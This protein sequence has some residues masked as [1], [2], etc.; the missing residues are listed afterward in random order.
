MFCVGSEPGKMQRRGEL[1]SKWRK[2]RT[3][4]AGRW[5]VRKLSQE[6]KDHLQGTRK[7]SGL[8][9]RLP[10]FLSHTPAH[11][12]RSPACT[13]VNTRQVGMPVR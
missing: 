1:R 6:G 10:D 11:T 3:G 13:H 8:S 4:V 5:Q 9:F 2:T 7:D 12:V